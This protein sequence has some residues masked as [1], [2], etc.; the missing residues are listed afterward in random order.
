M[1][2]TLGTTN[3]VTSTTPLWYDELAQQFGSQ[4]SGALDAA[5]SLGQNWYNQPLSA[6]TTN[7]QSNALTAAGTAGGAWSPYSAA[8]WNTMGQAAPQYQQAAAG[9]SQVAQGFG[10]AGAY[11]PAT[12]QQHLSPYIGGVVDEIGR[13]G[14]QNLTE[15]LLP[16][17]NQTFTGAGQF[18]GTR[19]ADFTNRALRDTQREVLGAQS[20]ALQ[21]AYTQAGQD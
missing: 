9:L 12:M 17:V 11:N 21:N 8:G 13:R 15:N 7:L 3:Q 20:N 10:G 16:Q 14:Q 5:G 18:G 6:G 1:S 2:D 4:I 19:N